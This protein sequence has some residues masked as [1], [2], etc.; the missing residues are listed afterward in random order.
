MSKNLV[1]GGPLTVLRIKSLTSVSETNE[2]CLVSSFVIMSYDASTKSLI[3]AKSRKLKTSARHPEASVISH[4]SHPNINL[5]YESSSE[6]YTSSSFSSV[7]SSDLNYASQSACGLSNHTADLGGIGQWM[8]RSGGGSWDAWQAPSDF[9][10]GQ[11]F[12]LS[13][14][15]ALAARSPFEQY[16]LMRRDGEEGLNYQMYA[17]LP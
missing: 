11:D 5:T 3:E 8:G 17:M 16:F 15:H 6:P 2:Y 10:E 14:I 12:D 13:K 4:N 9:T 7:E 1:L